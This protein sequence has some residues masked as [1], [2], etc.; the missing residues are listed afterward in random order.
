MTIKWMRSEGGG[1]Y[2]SP[3]GRF[4]IINCKRGV[5]RPSWVLFDRTRQD[6]NCPQCTWTVSCFT[7][8]DAKS[9]AER[10]LAGKAVQPC[11]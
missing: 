11:L 8:A 2:T 7:L 10:I 5:S 3:D 9:R 4:S 6:A 1:S